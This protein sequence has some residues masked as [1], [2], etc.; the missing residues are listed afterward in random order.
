MPKTRGNKITIWAI[1]VAMLIIFSVILF[2]DVKAWGTTYYLSASGDNSNSSDGCATAMDISDHNTASFNAGDTIYL[3][4]TGGAFPGTIIPP[5]SGTSGHPITYQNAPGHSPVIDCNSNGIADVGI[6]SQKAY[7]IIDGIT[8]KDAADFGIQI[9]TGGDNNKVKNCTVYDNTNVGILVG[10]VSNAT[11]GGSAGNGNTIQ[12]NCTSGDPS[13]FNGPNITFDDVTGGTISHNT[14]HNAWSYGIMVFSDCDNIT[15]EHNNI[16]ANGQ[17]DDWIGAGIAFYGDA[18]LQTGNICRYN[19]IHDE[20][21]HG[22]FVTN[23]I[24]GLQIYGNII[25]DVGL[26]SNDSG[27]GVGIGFEAG[28]TPPDAMKIYNNS[29]YLTNDH[30]YTSCIDIVAAG[31]KLENA[32]IKNNIFHV[33]G[34]TNY[35]YKMSVDNTNDPVLNYNIHYAPNHADPIKWENNTDCSFATLQS[36]YSQELNGYSSDPLFVDAAN[37]DFSLKSGSPCINNGTN[38]GDNYKYAFD[39][40]DKTFPYDLYDQNLYSPWEIGAF[41]YIRSY[42]IGLYIDV[43]PQ[44]A[45]RSYESE[46]INLVYSNEPCLLHGF[47]GRAEDAQVFLESRNIR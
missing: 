5:S 18:S 12:A 42:S 40:R 47:A 19:Y 41:V 7:V 24:N 44:I 31:G 16:Y 30:A 15:V 32:L 2:T 37:D 22:I 38:L 4:D 11:V 21:L 28:R 3:C 34:T 39:P 33:T 43:I 23:E 45:R 10:Y 29:M 20:L 17:Q 13:G 25:D 36:S 27:K 8:V 9:W 46:I 14:V 6:K 1:I 35:T 26:G